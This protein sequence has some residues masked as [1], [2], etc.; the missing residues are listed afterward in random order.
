MKRK[1]Y[2]TVGKEYRIVEKQIPKGETVNIPTKAKNVTIEKHDDKY[3][4]MYLQP[5]LV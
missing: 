4:V 2:R 5:K 3:I 1:E